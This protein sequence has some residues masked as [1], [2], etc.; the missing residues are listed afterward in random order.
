M[1][2]PKQPHSKAH[3]NQQLLTTKPYLFP[4]ISMYH[5]RQV[6]LVRAHQLALHYVV[7]VAGTFVENSLLELF[8]RLIHLLF[9]RLQPKINTLTRSEGCSAFHNCYYNEPTERQ[10]TQ[11]TPPNSLKPLRF[12]LQH[13]CLRSSPTVSPF[14][15]QEYHG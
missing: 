2:H 11:Q 9:L 8:V 15:S 14:C 7:H 1:W 13:V 3:C 10:C 12:P 5:F 4:V 6:Q